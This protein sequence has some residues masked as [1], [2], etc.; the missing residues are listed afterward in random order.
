VTEIWAVPCKRDAGAG[1]RAAAIAGNPA[2]CARGA[3]CPCRSFISLPLDLA[4]KHQALLLSGWVLGPGIGQQLRCAVTGVSPCL[5]V[6]GPQRRHKL[7]IGGIYWPLDGLA[8]RQWSVAKGSSMPPPRY[9]R[10]PRA[11]LAWRAG[12]SPCTSAQHVASIRNLSFSRAVGAVRVGQDVPEP[13]PHG[14]GGCRCGL[15]AG[16]RAS[17]GQQPALTSKHMHGRGYRMGLITAVSRAG[18]RGSAVRSLGFMETCEGEAL[19]PYTRIGCFTEPASA[20]Q[21]LQIIYCY[22]CVLGGSHCCHKVEEQVGD[23]CLIF[24]PISE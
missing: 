8:A 21:T 17:S 15:A 1:S 13:V 24:H 2:Q 14:G 4:D 16:C 3:S 23:C 20:H 12:H 22:S 9:A 6:Q 18:G 7:Y 19:C 10:H 5:P 11:I